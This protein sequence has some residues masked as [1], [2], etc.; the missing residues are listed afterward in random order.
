MMAKRKPAK[1]KK[2]KVTSDEGT[3]FSVWDHDN[4]FAFVISIST[5]NVYFVINNNNNISIAASLSIY[6]VC[7]YLLLCVHKRMYVV[8]I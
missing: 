2:K 8:K 1:R 4:K 6:L 5:V 3:H 7:V